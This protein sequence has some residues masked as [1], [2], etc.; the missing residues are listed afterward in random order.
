M[1]KMTLRGSGELAYETREV[2][3][4]ADGYWLEDGFFQLAKDGEV[5]GSVNANDVIEVR[6]VV[7]EPAATAA[8]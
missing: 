7:G 1:V 5:V 8:A 3:R 4:N 6:L 2:E